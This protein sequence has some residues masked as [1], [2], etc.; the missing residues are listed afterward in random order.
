MPIELV[1]SLAGID[2][3]NGGYWEAQGYDGTLESE[4]DTAG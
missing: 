2:G 1:S 4:R 3:G